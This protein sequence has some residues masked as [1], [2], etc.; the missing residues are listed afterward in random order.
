[1]K[2]FWILTILC[3]GI[4]LNNESYSQLKVEAGN[5]TAFCA[6]N[7]T[8]VSIGGNLSIK[9]GTPPYHIFW[10]AEYKVGDS[11]YTASWMLEDTT[12]A[13]PVLKKVSIHDSVM[14]YLTVTDSNYG[15]AMDSVKVGL[16]YFV[17][18]LGECRQ[19][20]RLGDS[21]QLGHC[22][23]GGIPPYKY[24][25]APANSLSDPHIEFPWAKPSSNTAYELKIMDAIE[26][27]NI[28]TCKILVKSYDSA[29]VFRPYQ[30]LLQPN[31]VWIYD[32][33][34]N[35][36]CSIADIRVKYYINGDTIVDDKV[37]AKLY[38]N[39]INTFAYPGQEGIYLASLLR[40]DSVNQKI[41]INYSLKQFENFD[42]FKSEEILYDFS[43]LP[44]DTIYF[45][46]YPYDIIRYGVVTNVD[47]L[48]LGN[49]ITIRRYYD[50]YGLLMGEY[51]GGELI[52][53]EPRWRELLAT[54]NRLRCVGENG[55]NIYGSGCE[56]V[57]TITE[58]VNFM[59]IFNISFD[60]NNW[61]LIIE[62][63]SGGII[64][65]YDLIGREIFST[66]VFSGES[67]YQVQRM[68]FKPGVAIYHFFDF[69]GR[70]VSGKLLIS[71]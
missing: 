9:G 51:I 66:K 45:H 11:I 25:W 4:F 22:V 36:P 31:K 24:F 59:D 38:G 35:G 39:P 56:G 57:T 46:S 50:V 20:I 16:S 8:N 54:E 17:S 48:K 44:G 37:Y 32:Y 12:V 13:N 3:L 65:L 55:V 15:E 62:T 40:E 41:Y 42:H 71:Y 29:I 2:S 14:F 30:R 53:F 47:T 61:C 63:E 19:N 23:T 67:S 43:V 60:Q 64:N 69:M 5:D 34:C 33:W 52:S 26:C 7:L 6:N 49:G 10:S 58:K 18:C 27:E 1:M 68:A 28:S 70:S 21:I